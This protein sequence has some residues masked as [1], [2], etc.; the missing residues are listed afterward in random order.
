MDP[1]TINGTTFT[2]KQGTT[3][4]TGVVTYSGILLLSNQQMLY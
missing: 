2:L 4:I 3:I 1:S